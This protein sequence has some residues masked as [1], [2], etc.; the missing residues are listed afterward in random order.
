VGRHREELDAPV[1]LGLL[2][3]A[4]SPAQPAF[5]PYNDGELSPGPRVE[6]DRQILDWVARD[7]ETALHPSCT[8]R[9]GTDE[10]SVVDPRRA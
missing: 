7:G 4:A 5:D 10:L 3:E 8:C 6:T 1:K 9:M 2:Q